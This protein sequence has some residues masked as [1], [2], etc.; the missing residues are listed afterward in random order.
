MQIDMHYYQAASYHR[1]YV[2]HELLPLHGLIVN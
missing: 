2:L 1:W